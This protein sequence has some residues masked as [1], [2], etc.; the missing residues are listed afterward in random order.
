[1]N[2]D[3]IST[4]VI[5][6]RVGQMRLVHNLQ[7]FV[8]AL[9]SKCNETSVLDDEDLVLWILDDGSL[10]LGHLDHGKTV[11]FNHGFRN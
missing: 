10:I 11:E 3:L 4:Y 9:E 7:D 5:R 2:P 6:N 1:M 8:R